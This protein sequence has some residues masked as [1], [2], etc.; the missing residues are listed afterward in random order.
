MRIA[1]QARGRMTP[2]L[3]GF[4]EI[5]IAA[6][7]GGKIAALAEEAFAAGNGEGHH[8]PVADLQRLVLGADLDHLAH[9]LMPD[10]VAML[11]LRDY[12]VVDVKIR[13]A[14]RAGGHLDDR[15]ARMLDFRI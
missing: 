3:L 15:V 5:R 7:A 2:E 11:H 1:E 8:D 12:T 13:A 9:G 14:D 10:D 4:L 6:L